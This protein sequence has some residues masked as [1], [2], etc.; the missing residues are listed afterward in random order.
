VQTFFR[1][2]RVLKAEEKLGLVAE[3]LCNLCHNFSGSISMS[4]FD[5]NSSGATAH[6]VEAGRINSPVPFRKSGLVKSHAFN[7]QPKP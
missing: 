2:F 3:Q 7:D 6:P 1:D 4:G 5:F